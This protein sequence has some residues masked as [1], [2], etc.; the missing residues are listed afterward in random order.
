MA[1]VDLRPGERLD[2]LLIGG[3]KII[4]DSSRFRFSLDAVLLGHFA[5]VKRQVTA[6]DLGSGT[7]VLGLI[8]A[9]RGAARVTGVE[10]DADMTAMAGRTIA[11]NGLEDRLAVLS[12]DVRNIGR[13]LP[14]GCADLVVSNPPYRAPGSGQESPRPAVALARHELAG[15]LADFVKAAAY[16]LK[17]KGRLALVQLPERLP[18]IMAALAGCS[19]E[20]KRLRLV[21][22]APGREAKLVLIEAV[23]GGRPGLK[24]EAPLFVYEESGGY[25]REILAYYQAGE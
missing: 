14:A 13:L 18:A 7:G 20:P 12:G 10:L 19:L 25:T 24:V 1:N 22:S 2:D 5:T 3:F 21:H 11:L 4:Q 16:L 6:V 15:G 9:A 17:G 23:A 8:L